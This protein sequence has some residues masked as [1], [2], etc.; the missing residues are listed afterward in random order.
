MTGSDPEPEL[1][2]QKTNALLEE[3]FIILVSL[4]QVPVGLSPSRINLNHLCHCHI[5]IILFFTNIDNANEKVNIL[6][7]LAVASKEEMR[8]LMLSS[9]S[10]D[11]FDLVI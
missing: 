5:G 10:S 6:S 11:V 4:L 3:G 9:E 8:D 7:M 2:A 1:P